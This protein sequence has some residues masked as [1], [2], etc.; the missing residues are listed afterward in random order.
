MVQLLRKR[1]RLLPGGGADVWLTIR[2][3]Q[4]ALSWPDSLKVSELP[5]T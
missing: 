3:N 1:L 2:D 4:R 5:I